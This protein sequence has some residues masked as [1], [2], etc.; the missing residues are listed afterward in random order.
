MSAGAA[1]SAA[2]LLVTGCATTTTGPSAANDPAARRQEID[3]GANGALTR[4]YSAARGSEELANR[5]RGILIFPRVLSAGLGVG[6]EFGDG[7]LRVGGK[8]VGY[9]RLVSGSLGWQIGAQ[10][11]A[12]VLM[13][14][15]DDALNRFRNSHG[16]TIGADAAVAVA[17]IGAS[18]TVD[19]NTARQS[20]VG[21]AL[22]N[23][24]LYAGVKLEGGKITRLDL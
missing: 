6:G 15:T 22:T 5:A 21:F 16:W 14:L 9:Y 3:S 19:T 24:G 12:I 11:Q 20:I 18:G 7:V 17:K 23:T 2:A 13:F 10:S 1:L 8:D 4:L